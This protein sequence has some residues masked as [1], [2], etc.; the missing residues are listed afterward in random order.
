MRLV[1]WVYVMLM[2]ILPA[3]AV[4]TNCSLVD[5][6]PIADFTFATTPSETAPIPV[7]FYTSSQGGTTDKGRIVDPV[8]S[9]FWQFG[10]GDMSERPNPSH[11]YFMSSA[12]YEADDEPFTVTLRVK[13]ECGR[14]N[15]TTKNVSVY[16]LDQKAGFELVRP[17]GD[18]PYAAPVVL[19][20]RDT[21]LHVHDSVTAYH[22]T[23]WDA[24][25]TRLFFESTEKDPTFV[26]RN[27][28]SYLIR[29]S[30]F[31]GCSNPPSNKTEMTMAISVTGTAAS[32][33]IPMETIPFTTIVPALPATTTQVATSAATPTSPVTPPATSPP[34]PAPGTGT[35]SVVTSPAGARVFV[36]DIQLGTS[37]AT[38]PGFL[39]GSY[40]LRIEKSGY[41]NKTFPFVIREGEVT[42]YSATLEPESGGPGI[43]PLV[44]AV[45]LVAGGTGAAY[46]F[47]KRKK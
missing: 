22:Y 36:N 20:I 4:V 2:I 9:Y 38:I 39:A 31:K 35:L 17:A 8:E 29:Q 12:R 3:S 18:G 47:V 1:G 10:D 37:P 30:V 19:M 6:G 13:T 33:A 32:D 24:G 23:L 7:N 21:S 25:M 44:A 16:C 28:G 27:G 5:I 34:V 42:E 40:G 11:T 15:A 43:V 26:I 46:W 14:S 41:R 45:A